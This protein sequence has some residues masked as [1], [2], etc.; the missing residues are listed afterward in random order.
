MTCPTITADSPRTLLVSPTAGASS[1][2]E[3]SGDWRLVLEHGP[4]APASAR[5]AAR[6]VMRAWGV[7]EE[8][9]DDVLMVVSEFVT[10]AVHYAEPPIA[11]NLGHCDD[12]AVLVSVTDGG[13]RAVEDQYGADRPADEH[14]RGTHI[15]DALAVDAGAAAGDGLVSHWAVVSP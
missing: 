13:P 4:Q 2:S 9:V 15:V 5:S 1:G 14:G 12:Q 11:V 3:T 7:H 8:T 10:N 6:R